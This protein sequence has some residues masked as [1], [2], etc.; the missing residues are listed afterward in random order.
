VALPVAPQLA[1]VKLG[2]G[3]AGAMTTPRLPTSTAESTVTDTTALP[4]NA[5]T[6]ARVTS[7]TVD[8]LR[9]YRDD[10]ADRFKRLSQ[11]AP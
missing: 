7:L 9:Q 11:P 5:V 8:E 1:C 2:C 3:D 4:P 10:L 6:A